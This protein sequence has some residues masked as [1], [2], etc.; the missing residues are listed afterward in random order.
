MTP[1]PNGDF[2]PLNNLSQVLSEEFEPVSVCHETA[3]LSGTKLTPLAKS[4]A[5]CQL[6]GV[7]AGQRS[8]LVEV[9]VDGGMDGGEFLQAS[10][11]PETLHGA[12][13]SSERQVRVL[14]A[15]VEPPARPLFFERTQFSERGSV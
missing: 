13:A 15:V 8:S 5:A 14:D 10:H 4:G 1:D 6:E 7:S 3:S 11:S 9:V 12:F 2:A